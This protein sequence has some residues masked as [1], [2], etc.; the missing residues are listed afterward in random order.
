MVLKVRKLETAMMML[1][2][3]N[4]VMESDTVLTQYIV[5]KW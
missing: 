4:V 1:N 2:P 5:K 3:K